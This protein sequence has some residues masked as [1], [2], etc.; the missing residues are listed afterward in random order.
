MGEAH[1]LVELSRHEN[2]EMYEISMSA[3][4]LNSLLATS[5]VSMERDEKSILIEE[6]ADAFEAR[7][8]D[9]NA[10]DRSRLAWLCLH[11]RDVGRAQRHVA[12]PVA[13][14]L[15]LS[16]DNEHCLKLKERL[17]RQRSL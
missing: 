3:N 2:V 14:G 7:I 13:A 16:P 15:E 5:P 4:R 17:E 8:D 9:G 10:S 12:S 1:A 11:L 6:M